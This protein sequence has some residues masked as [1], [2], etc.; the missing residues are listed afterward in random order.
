[1]FSPFFF[2]PA[3]ST[4]LGHSASFSFHALS[5]LNAAS[6]FGRII[7]GTLA[8]RFGPFNLSCISALVGAVV[9][10]CWTA[11]TSPAGLGVWAV[12]YGFSSGVSRSPVP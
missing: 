12:A 8:D 10:Y 2:T 4:S 9:C 7:I 6:L 5:I 1:M 3:Y 11:A